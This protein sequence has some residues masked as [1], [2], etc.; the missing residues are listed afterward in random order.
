MSEA[1]QLTAMARDRVGKGAAR[2][3]RRQG[4]VPAVIYGAGEPAEPIA[5][6]FNQT[7][8]LI[9]GGGFLTTVFDIDVGGRT[10][11][12]IPRDYQL[13]PV[14]DFPLHVDFLRLAEGQTVTVEVPVHFVNQEDS[15]GLK[16][17]GTLNIV[18]HAVE[19]TVPADAIP[20]ALEA[21]VG[22]LDINDSLHISA[23]TLPEGAQLTITDRDFTVATIAVPAG[24]NEEEEAAAPEGEGEAAQAD[25]AP[26]T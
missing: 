10:V 17:G 1:K 21:D 13:D 4:H 2:A 15:P 25:E 18:R 22:A 9:F 3:V 26:Q 20:D 6:D 23:I 14:K 12:A 24:F 5:L 16:R 19:L 7:R 11:R 8:Q